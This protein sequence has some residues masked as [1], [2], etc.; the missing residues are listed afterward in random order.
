[1]MKQL[2]RRSFLK[3]A[4]AV[5]GGSF[6]LPAT[7]TQA[8]AAARGNGLSYT[9]VNKTGGRF[10][11]DQCFWSLDGGRAWRSFAQAPSVPCP[12]GNGRVYFR[13]GAAPKNLDDRHA[14]WDFIQPSRAGRP[15]RLEEPSPVLPRGTVQLVRQVP[16]RAQP[17]PQGLRL[18]LRRRQRASRVLQRQRAE[19]DRNL[20]LGYRAGP[21]IAGI[22]GSSGHRHGKRETVGRALARLK[23]RRAKA[24]PTALPPAQ[25]S[26]NYFPALADETSGSG[27]RLGTRSA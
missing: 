4:A 1:M 3:G 11:D 12:G 6:L 13:L 21:R 2:S 8:Q 10:A 27:S 22:I 23:C 25:D 26:P 17:R 18:L 9:F 14:Y 5:G 20:V 24:H 16:P 7:F 15:G 19:P